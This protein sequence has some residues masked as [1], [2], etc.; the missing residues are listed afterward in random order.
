MLFRSGINGRARSFRAIREQKWNREVTGRVRSWWRKVNL[1]VE[2]WNLTP[3]E[4]SK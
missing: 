2:L 1:A 4:P 3:K